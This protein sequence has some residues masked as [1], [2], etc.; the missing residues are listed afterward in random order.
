M[1]LKKLLSSASR[2]EV[3]ER[4]S[5]LIKSDSEFISV[6]QRGFSRFSDVQYTVPKNL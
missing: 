3:S 4:I 5:G 1:I 2:V 6:D